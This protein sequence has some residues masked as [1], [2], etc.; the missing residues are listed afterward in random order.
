MALYCN[1]GVYT[2]NGY[3]YNACTLI[4]SLY[5]IENGLNN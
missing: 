1:S 2:T 5:A 3:Q 4:I